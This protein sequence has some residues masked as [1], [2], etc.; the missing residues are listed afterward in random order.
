V[1][2]GEPLLRVT[3]T[4]VGAPPGLETPENEGS[5]WVLILLSFVVLASVLE[6]VIDDQSSKASKLGGRWQF[7]RRAIYL[8]N[9]CREA[10]GNP[11]F[12][13]VTNKPAVALKKGQL[14][15][16]YTF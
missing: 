13:Q 6:T 3:W 16:K 12:N 14:V 9:L 8:A 4:A 15:R 10:L 7:S 1:L 2:F 5:S 11:S